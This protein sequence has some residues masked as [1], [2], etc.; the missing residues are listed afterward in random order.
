MRLIK[1]AGRNGFT[2][3]ELLVVIVIVAA[4]AALSFTV[5]PKMLAKGKATE[6]MQNLR[7]IGPLL[8]TY[9]ADHELKYPPVKAP[10]LMQDG[11]MG[12]Q[13]WHETCLE[14]LFP[15]VVPADFKKKEWW[16]A[17]KKTVLRNPLFLETAK[18]R[19]W[20]PLNPGYAMNLMIPENLAI[21]SGGP[22]PS[23]NDLLATSVPIA[24]IEEPSRAPLIAPCDN[25]FFRYEEADLVGFKS[26]TLKSLM[27]EGKIPILFVDGHVE[28]VS[29][30][31]YLE[32]K[33]FLIPI[34]PT[35]IP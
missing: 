21:A 32:R 8:A 12:E 13:Y 30:S 5:G 14:L 6:S 11:T 18:P 15:E 19:G 24:A 33:L 17:N 20:T 27:T 28:S 10:A 29:P 25:Y 16:A 7:Q 26:G 34:A 22:V 2:L 31:E 23:Q 35:P 1:N 3:V 9:A 4:L